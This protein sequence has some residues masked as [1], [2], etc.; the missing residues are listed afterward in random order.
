MTAFMQALDYEVLRATHPNVLIVGPDAAIDHA[1]RALLELCRQ[2]VT[3]NER[4]HALVLP[5]RSNAGTLI[6]PDVGHLSLND[7]HRLLAWLEVPCGGAQVV[8]TS[9]RPLYTCLHTG[10]FLE[11]LYYRLNVVYLDLTAT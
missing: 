8:A 3:T 6:L 9:V 4:N 2:P 1:L 5:S 11:R 7:Q 10:A